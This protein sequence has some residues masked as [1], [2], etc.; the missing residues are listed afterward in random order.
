LIFIISKSDRSCVKKVPGCR[1]PCGFTGQF[2]VCGST[3]TTLE[4]QS[5]LCC[6]HRIFQAG[7]KTMRPRRSLTGE[8][9][10]PESGGTRSL[11]DRIGKRLQAIASC[12][13]EKRKP[14]GNEISTFGIS[15]R[16]PCRRHK[17]R[18]Q[19][20]KHLAR[21]ALTWPTCAEVPEAS[22]VWVIAVSLSFCSAG[23]CGVADGSI[24]NAPFGCSI[25]MIP[26]PAELVPMPW[27]RLVKVASR[28]II[29]SVPSG[30]AARK[31]QTK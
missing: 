6:T 13:P 9:H 5:D 7:R 23:I 11:Q 22:G 26:Y 19:G 18:R 29:L 3:L 25:F 10:R 2:R 20:C 21:S 30:A 8:G 24:G 4:V 28:V 14:T 1:N 31:R 16:V 17:E 12:A 27:H 15:P